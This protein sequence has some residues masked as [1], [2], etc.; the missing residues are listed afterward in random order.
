VSILS[1]PGIGAVKE[2]NS[3]GGTKVS[4]KGPRRQSMALW[5]RC[6][7]RSVIIK[8]KDSRCVARVWSSIRTETFNKQCAKAVALPFADKTK[9]QTN[10]PATTCTPFFLYIH[11]PPSYIPPSS[12]FPSA[13]RASQTSVL[14]KFKK[15]KRLRMKSIVCQVKKQQSCICES[16]KKWT[17]FAKSVFNLSNIQHFSMSY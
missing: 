17:F 10:P 15:N 7:R 8:K 13:P 4:A 3:G 5:S 16:I 6:H 2:R 1:V 14:M 12:I 9:K 11:L